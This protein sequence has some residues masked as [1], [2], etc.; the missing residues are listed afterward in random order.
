M[1]YSIDRPAAHD[2][3]RRPNIYL[4]KR[5]YEALPAAYASIGM[6]FILGAIYI[7]IGRWLTTVYLAVG[8]SCIVA[9]FAVNSIRHRERTKLKKVMA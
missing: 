9:G 1:S 5:I 8:V 3:P 7:G 4:P 2:Y 6:L